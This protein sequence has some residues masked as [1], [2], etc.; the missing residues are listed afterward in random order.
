[1]SLLGCAAKFSLLVVIVAV[2]VAALNVDAGILAS[3][4]AAVVV[5][6]AAMVAASVAVSITKTT[7]SVAMMFPEESGG[8]QH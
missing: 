7:G 4:S 2:G 3:G 5:V 1:L 6:R 8:W